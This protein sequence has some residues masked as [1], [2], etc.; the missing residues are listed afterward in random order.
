MKMNQPSMSVILKDG[1]GRP[2]LL[3]AAAHDFQLRAQLSGTA[4]AALSPQPC[5]FTRL[6]YFKRHGCLCTCR[7]RQHCFGK[8]TMTSCTQNS[9]AITIVFLQKLNHRTDVARSPTMRTAIAAIATGEILGI[10]DAS[11][12]K[13]RIFQMWKNNR[14]PSIDERRLYIAHGIGE[15][16]YM[17]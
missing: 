16:L 17:L 1:H 4:P 11:A 9:N 10:V 8:P 6:A 12:R 7:L 14:L 3:H 2:L 15:H 5:Y 13:L